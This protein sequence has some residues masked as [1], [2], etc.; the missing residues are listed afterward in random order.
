[1][2]PGVE[3]ENEIHFGKVYLPV[4]FLMRVEMVKNGEALLVDWCG[5]SSQ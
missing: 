3:K 2:D 4:R 5:S 1:L